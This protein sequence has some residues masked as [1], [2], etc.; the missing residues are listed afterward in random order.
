MLTLQKTKRNNNLWDNTTYRV[1]TPEGEVFITLAE[2]CPGKI[3]HVF[4]YVGKAGSLVRQHADATA[5]LTGLA[6][7]NG[8]PIRQVQ[9]ILSGIRSDRSNYIISRLPS[10]GS[11]QEA[12][13]YCLEKYLQAYESRFGRIRGGFRLTN[14]RRA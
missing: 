4:I 2:A 9:V 13:V 1:F 12:L 5:S 10:A 3:E 11:I 8:T 7:R 6:L 14:P